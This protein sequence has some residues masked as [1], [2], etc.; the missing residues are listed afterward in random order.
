MILQQESAQQSGGKVFIG[1]H[2]LGC[3]VALS[4]AAKR[5]EN[6]LGI[7]LASP[8]TSM[9][10]MDLRF[11]RPWSYLLLFW[12]WASDRWDNI[13]AAASLPS[14]VPVALLS[15]GA[16]QIVPEQMHRQ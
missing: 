3:S 1:G 5:S 10:D 13:G 12:L 9:W 8:F 6:V 2:S 11:V 4:L 14:D 7:I 16:D 15:A